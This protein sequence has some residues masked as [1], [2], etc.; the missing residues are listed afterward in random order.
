M[1][2]GI[3]QNKKFIMHNK[4]EKGF[5]GFCGHVSVSTALVIFSLEEYEWAN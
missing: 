3:G 4:T 5:K 2:K 1:T